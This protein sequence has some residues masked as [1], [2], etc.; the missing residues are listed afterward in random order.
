M[1]INLLDQGGAVHEVLQTFA[2]SLKHFVQSKEYLEQ[3]RLNQL[4]KDAQRAAL[5]IKDR[6]K[7]AESLEFTLNLTSSRLRSLS[8]LVLY[9][10]SL[11]ASPGDMQS[12]A[13]PDINLETIGEL[14]AQSEIDFRSLTANVRELLETRSQVSIGDVLE[15]FPAAQ[16]L[17]SIV[18]LIAL[19]CRHGHKILNPAGKPAEETVSWIGNDS[20]KRIA[21]IPK[22]FF[23]KE[24]ANELVQ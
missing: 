9:D 14:V 23:L 18:G 4:L 24:S 16:G 13:A 2:R 5:A 22:I 19:G 3:R 20:E 8:Q 10:P 12:G 7:T 6:V 1:I 11:K 17:G 15:F 21:R